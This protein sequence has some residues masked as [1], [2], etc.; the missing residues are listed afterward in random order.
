MKQERPPCPEPGCRLWCGLIKVGP[1][2]FIATTCV[3]HAW[4]GKFIVP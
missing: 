1:T 2:W 4:P 3:R